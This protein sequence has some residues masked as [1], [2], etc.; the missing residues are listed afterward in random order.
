M[1]SMSN[2]ATS[3]N[4][5]ASAA[6]ALASTRP[7]YQFKIPESVRKWPT[8]PAV[9]VLREI[10]LA[11]EQA[12]NSMAGGFGYKM[13]VECLKH[14]IVSADGKAIT[15]DGADKEVFIE[16]LSPLTRDLM[17][18]AY[19]RIHNTAEAVQEDFFASMQT[20]L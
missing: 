2:V 13:S 14:A 18:R 17:L 15:W 10:T 20:V 6:Q 11:E 1:P 19:S 12:A 3:P 5:P 9:V 8:D 4:S 7:K 16:G